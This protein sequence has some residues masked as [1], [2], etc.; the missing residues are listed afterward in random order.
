MSGQDKKDP[1]DLFN[2]PQTALGFIAVYVQVQ[3]TWAVLIL[4]F[5]AGLLAEL[6]A[7]DR[8]RLSFSFG[9]DLLVLYE[10]LLAGLCYTID[11]FLVATSVVNKGKAL[12]KEKHGEPI[13]WKSWRIE[14]WLFRNGEIITY[15]VILIFVAVVLF[16]LAL[17]A[18]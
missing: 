12:F 13:G 4:A 1:R 5:L 16:E 11:R 2:D 18:I 7:L 14:S 8:I 17:F 10:L 9:I 6:S 3:T 15:E